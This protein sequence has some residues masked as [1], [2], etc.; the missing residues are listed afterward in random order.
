MKRSIVFMLLAV[1]VLGS[2]GLWNHL[3][4]SAEAN[5][6]ALWIFSDEV[7]TP[8]AR[9][10]LVQRSAARGV[11]DLYLSVYRSALNRAVR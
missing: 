10:T 9:D 1:V 5:V 7:S 4:V 3:P 6:H 2:V 11:T 8:A